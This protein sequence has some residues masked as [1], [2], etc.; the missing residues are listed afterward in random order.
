M[1]RTPDLRTAILRQATLLVRRH[2][3]YCSNIDLEIKRRNRRSTSSVGKKLYTPAHWELADGFHPYKVRSRVDRIAHSIRARIRNGT[4][5]PFA[6]MIK[7]IGKSTGAPRE[8][9]I[10]Q[11]ADSAVS[12]R[13]FRSLVAKNYSL[14][15]QYSYAYRTEL[16]LHDA[17]RQL[18]NSLGAGPRVYIGQV[19]FK[20]YFGSIRHES[21]WKTLRD[22][23]FLVSR[24]EQIIIEAFLKSREISFKDYSSREGNIRKRGVPQGT[25]ISLFLANVAATP[26]DRSLEKLGV[27]FARYGDD[28]IIWSDDY[29]LVNEAINQLNSLGTEIGVELNLEKSEGVFLLTPPKPKPEIAFRRTVEFVGYSIKKQE[30][31]SVI[32][33]MHP[34]AIAGIKSRMAQ[35]IHSNLL[36]EPKRGTQNQTRLTG[37][38]DRDFVV[39][40]M[41]LQRYLYGDLT[42]VKIRRYMGGYVPNIRYQGRMAFYP[43]IG[44]FKLL[45]SLDGWLLHTIFLA[46]KKRHSILKG[47]NITTL[48]QP[49]GLSKEQLSSARFLINSPGETIEIPSFF[50][51]GKILAAAAD[52]YGANTI[53]HRRSFFFRSS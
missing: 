50:S 51:I 19:D 6:A 4:Y 11:I 8:V 32:T 42:D 46:L 30:D 24:E 37:K 10:Y 7:E 14:F 45:K 53:A 22:L 1:I 5:E 27:H 15:S 52:A 28:T 39:M 18:K 35:I 2:E 38:N 34:K 12:F 33:S 9:N 29:G 25:S 47:Q 40:L 31:G 23:G 13:A 43:M 3:K 44:D 21:I 41:Q 20:S 48:V 16:T 17:I 36:G 26:I 49:F